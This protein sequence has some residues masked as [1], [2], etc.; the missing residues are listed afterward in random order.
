VAVVTGGA[1]LGTGGA[2]A[3]VQPGAL[4]PRRGEPAT[5]DDGGESSS[6]RAPELCSGATLN[7]APGSSAAYS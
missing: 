1:P 7:F 4:S 2:V 6:D 3:R 5:S